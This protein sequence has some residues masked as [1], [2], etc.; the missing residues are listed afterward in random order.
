MTISSG[1]SMPLAA[2]MADAVVPNCCAMA[3]RVSPCW[4]TYVS[5]GGGGGGG[6]AVGTAVGTGVGAGVGDGPG[7][8]VG[9]AVA[10][11]EAE[12]LGLLDAGGLS[13]GRTDADAE[14]DAELPAP[15]NSSPMAPLAT[16]TPPIARATPPAPMAISGPVDAR[17]ARPAIPRHA[18][19]G[20]R[21][22]RVETRLSMM[23]PCAGR[24][25]PL[26]LTCA[27]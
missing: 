19:S 5:C 17:R 2:C 27:R 12:V 14:A 9:L 10:T 15:V 3:A 21:I 13:E 6:G 7:L 20:A 16:A 22:K 18:G 11:A 25:P 26:R 4:T 24:R 8:D 1:L 23:P